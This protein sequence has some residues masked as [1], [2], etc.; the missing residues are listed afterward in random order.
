MDREWLSLR[1]RPSSSASIAIY[2][3]LARIHTPWPMGTS[4]VAP[5]TSA[6]VTMAPRRQRPPGAQ[7][8]SGLCSATGDRWRPAYGDGRARPPQTLGRR[9]RQRQW[10]E[11]AWLGGEALDVR[12]PAMGGGVWRAESL[13][14]SSVRLATEKEPAT[15][16]LQD[17]QDKKG[18]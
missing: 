16:G 5:L 8:P 13:I 9:A 10:A 15:Y 11:G 4:T 14:P 18:G 1:C 6:S 12:P 3:R 17:S 2:G 7:A